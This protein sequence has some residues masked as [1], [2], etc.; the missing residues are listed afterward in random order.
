MNEQDILNGL[1]HVWPI[2]KGSQGVPVA[3]LTWMG[4]L[5]V[6]FKLI[7]GKIEDF[8]HACI[9]FYAD[10]KDEAALVRIDSF[11]HGRLYRFAAFLTDYLTSVKLPLAVDRSPKDPARSSGDA[12]KIGG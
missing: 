7:S 4:F 6:G 3:I 9:A 8:A 1:F 12:P 10:S 5:R 2:L 11:L